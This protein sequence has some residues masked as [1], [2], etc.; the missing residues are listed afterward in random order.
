MK[1]IRLAALGRLGLISTAVLALSNGCSP[2]TFK[3]LTKAT[4]GDVTF[5]FVNATPY[6][7]AFSF[8]TY[9]AWDNSPGPVELQQLRLNANE[10]SEATTVTCR[11]NAA[12]GTADF[13]QRVIAT[14]ADNIEDFDPEAFSD[15]IRF[16]SVP[17]DAPGGG[18]PTEGTARGIER[19]LGVHY[20]CADQLVFT[21]VQDPDAEGGFRVDFSVIRDIP[22]E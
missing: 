13:V 18:L 1:R 12:V 15:V 2:D 4:T 22:L 8:G 17:G 11:R 3:N 20:S 5:V 21:F 14:D 6:A 10:S 16:S 7:A 9:D 19:L